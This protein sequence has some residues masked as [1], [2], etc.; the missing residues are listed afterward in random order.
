MVPKEKKII[1]I[2]G[3]LSPFYNKGNEHCSLAMAPSISHGIYGYKAGAL[4]SH[5]L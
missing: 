4:G 3:V 1:L 2:T 5:Q